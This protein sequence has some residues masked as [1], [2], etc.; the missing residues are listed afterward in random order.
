LLTGR[1]WTKNANK[2]GVCETTQVGC[3]L[4]LLLLAT[5]FP[6]GCTLL[7]YPGPSL[8]FK[9][10]TAITHAARRAAIFNANL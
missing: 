2:G 5:A 10:S 1:L 4:L 7:F 6:P 9:A 8:L 3:I